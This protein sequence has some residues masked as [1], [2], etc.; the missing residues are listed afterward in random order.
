MPRVKTLFVDDNKMKHHYIEQF[1]DQIKSDMEIDLKCFD[2]PIVAIE[3]ALSSEYDII[4][5]DYLMPKMDGI[6]FLQIYRRNFPQTPVIMITSEKDDQSLKIKALSCGVS[7][8]LT[9][10]C[11][12]PEFKA[13]F[14]NLVNLRLMQKEIEK[15]AEML[16]IEVMKAT[17]N[18]REREKETLN[19]LA[20]LTEY[21][22]METEIHTER[23]AKYSRLLA[24]KC[25]LSDKQIEI[26][27][28]S[29]PLH[30]I[31]KIGIPDHVLLKNGKY[32]AHEYEIMKNHTLIG[33][34]ILENTKSK[35]LTAGK[36]IALSHH[37][38][39]DGYGYPNGIKG[40][41]IPILARIVTIADVFDALLSERSYKSAWS[42]DEAVKYLI[43][44]KGKQFDPDLIDMFIE[45]TNEVESI[46]L[47]MNK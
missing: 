47:S 39:Y 3:S 30:D 8:F 7:D 37:E 46:Y 41:E 45:N 9:Y 25:S 5:L 12:F 14:C 44:Q 35:F 26:V 19:V 24:Q 27:Y 23:V 28:F 33:Y 11:S 22:D 34:R 31:G 18:V 13:R 40:D 38:R 20:K 16:E 29:A 32:D 21:K 42:F 17:Q 1:I 6:E 10:P 2:D 43:E 36:E 15:K 4:L